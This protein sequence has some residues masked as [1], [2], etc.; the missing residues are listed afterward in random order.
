MHAA[1]GPQGQ[2]GDA[3]V[4]LGEA[5]QL[6]TVPP[7]LP[8]PWSLV[9][10]AEKLPYRAHQRFLPDIGRN[11]GRITT[12]SNILLK[13]F[14]PSHKVMPLCDLVVIHGGQG[15]VQSAIAAGVPLIGIPLQPEQFFN[16]KQVERHG[17][18]RCLSL[19]DFKKGKLK[20]T[21]QDLLGDPNSRAAMG[22]LQRFQ[23]GRNGPCEVARAIR[24]LV[25]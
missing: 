25:A 5:T 23:A 2:D 21:I 22:K 12:S 6:V 15:S 9:I 14:L 10:A 20:A 16:V 4:G 24:Q 8:V 18:G 3:D 17:A 1:L 13:R 7:R 19:R 11:T